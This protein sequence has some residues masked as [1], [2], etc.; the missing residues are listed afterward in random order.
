MDEINAVLKGVSALHNE[1]HHDFDKLE[2]EVMQDH[3]SDLLTEAVSYTQSAI[4]EI[5]G[6]NSSQK[7]RQVAVRIYGRNCPKHARYLLEIMND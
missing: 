2:N 1:I 7:S 6:D 5:A 3:C 4:E